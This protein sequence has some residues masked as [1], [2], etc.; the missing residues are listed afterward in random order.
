MGDTVKKQLADGLA[1]INQSQLPGK[2]KV[3]Y[4]QF[5]LCHRLMWPLKMS[6]ISFSVVSK[7]D[8]LAKS[9]IRKWLGLAR[10]LSEVGLF[11][12]NTLQLPLQSISLG[13]KQEKARLVLELRE[14][15]D[16]LVRAVG[17]QIRMGRKWSTRQ[18]VG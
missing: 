6:E 14:S 13:Y 12:R 4:Y 15:T 2:Y 8:G 16:Q 9:Y 18:S 7:M 11:S 3:W 1:M 17:T 5:I 10:C